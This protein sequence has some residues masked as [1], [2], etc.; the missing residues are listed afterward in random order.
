MPIRQFFTKD[1]A[2]EP[3]DLKAMSEAFSRALA[4]LHLHDR[5]DPIV[6]LVAGRII[7]AALQGERDPVKL[8]EIAIDDPGRVSAA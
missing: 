5:K 2:F 8:C 3:D 7:R 6:E 1:V 4:E